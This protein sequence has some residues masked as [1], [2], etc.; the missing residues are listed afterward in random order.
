MIAKNKKQNN[1][2]TKNKKMHQFYFEKLDVWQNARVLVKDMY[3]VTASF[4]SE[5]V[6][7]ITSQ[8]RRATMSIS[9]NIAEG[10]SRTTNK[11]KSRFLNMSF[12]SAMEVVNFL[13]LSLD[14]EYLNNEQYTELREQLEKITNQLQALSRRLV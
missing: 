2:L 12:S 11:E 3:R 6:F 4:P 9:A 8:I 7:G 1:E 10:I 13:I 5:E 14:L